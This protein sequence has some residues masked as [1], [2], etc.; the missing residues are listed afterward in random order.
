MSEPDMRHPVLVMPW[1]GRRAEMRLIDWEE[2][3][4]SP[5]IG[6]VVDP[7]RGEPYGDVVKVE[8]ELRDY[9]ETPPGG[10]RLSDEIVEMPLRD[11]L[12]YE[13]RRQD[14][15]LEPW[16]RTVRF[17]FLRQPPPVSLSPNGNTVADAYPEVRDFIREIL[18]AGPV[19][20]SEIISKAAELGISESA[21][22]TARARLRI[23]QFRQEGS[24]DA[25]ILWRLR[26]SQAYTLKRPR[27]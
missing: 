4:Q 23:A 27:D 8:V 1:P 3:I 6:L 16:V 2:Y 25:A 11:Y 18:T 14:L 9:I 24:D 5:L 7:E 21:L 26:M 22:E 10:R 15:G 12:T 20:R 19:L 17:E 13:S